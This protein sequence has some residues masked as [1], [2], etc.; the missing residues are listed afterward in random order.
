MDVYS[1]GVAGQ[2]AESSFAHGIRHL[3][4]AFQGRIK[5]FHLSSTQ[6]SETLLTALLSLV[7]RSWM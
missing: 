5:C 2:G 6:C 3:L 4:A 7:L 1:S